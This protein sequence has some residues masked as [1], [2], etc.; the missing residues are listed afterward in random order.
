[1]QARSLFNF[2]ADSFSLKKARGRIGLIHHSTGIPVFLIYLR[3][4]EDSYSIPSLTV[5]EV[6][7][8]LQNELY[9]ENRKVWTSIRKFFEA[10]G[11]RAHL[12]VSP[13]KGKASSEVL[14]DLIGEDLGF[15]RRSGIYSIKSIIERVDLVVVPQAA[16]ILAKND[17]RIFCQALFDFLKNQRNLFALIDS[18]MGPNPYEVSEW[19]HTLQSEDSALFYPWMIENDEIFPVTPF[20]AA[21]YQLNDQEF[22]LAE[23]PTNCNLQGNAIPLI[24]LSASQSAELSQNRI[25]TI[26]AFRDSKALLWGA[27]TLA[28]PDSDYRFVA[29]RRTIKALMDALTAICDQFVLEP[30]KEATLTILQNEL[31]DFCSVHKHLFNLNK[32]KPYQVLVSEVLIGRG[33]EAIQVDCEFYLNTCIDSLQVSIGVKL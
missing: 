21:A 11:E 2:E 29:T 4:V 25:N 3:G 31:E 10:G 22:H 17:Y 19:V 1:M 9:P 14:V 12:N 20:I 24:R 16:F 8:F 15:T 32:S 23:S 7:T 33:Q 26:L 13:L 30:L 6:D 27:A 18:P 28:P 5:V